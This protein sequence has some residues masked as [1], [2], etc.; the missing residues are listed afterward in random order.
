M[1][2]STIS[3]AEDGSVLYRMVNEA[4][5]AVPEA[6]VTPPSR[7]MSLLTPSPREGSPRERGRVNKT[8]VADGDEGASGDKVKL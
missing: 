3:V 7:R 5:A 6:P 4:L 2:L 8:F 1:G